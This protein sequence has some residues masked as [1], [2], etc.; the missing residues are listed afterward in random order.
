MEGGVGFS[1]GYYVVFRNK[2]CDLR[3]GYQGSGFVISCLAGYCWCFGIGIWVLVWGT[4]LSG[5]PVR[6]Q[7]TSQPNTRVEVSYSHHHPQTLHQATQPPISP[8]YPSSSTLRTK[9]HLQTPARTPP[10][11]PEQ[12]AAPRSHPSTPL[13]H[14]PRVRPWRPNPPRPAASAPGDTSPD[15]RSP[16]GRP[17]AGGP[18]RVDR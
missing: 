2:V 12:P 10:K 4:G 16:P 8:I 7:D 9:I 3:V 5:H 6:E 17:S 14:R 18:W 1:E 13:A 11:P 15:R